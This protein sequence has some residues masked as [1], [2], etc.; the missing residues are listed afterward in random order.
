[1]SLGI[2]QLQRMMWKDDLL[3]KLDARI[4][5]AAISPAEF[6]NIEADEFRLLQAHGEYDISKKMQVLMQGFNGKIGTHEIVPFVTA[7]GTTI[8]VNRGWVPIEEK[9][10]EVSGNHELNGVIRKN[11]RKGYF[12]LENEPEKNTWYNIELPEMYAKAGVA[13]LGYYVE[14]RAVDEKEELTYPIPLPKKIDIYNQHLQYVI[15]WFGMSIALLIMY[16]FRFFHNKN[17]AKK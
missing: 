2:W 17:G 5:M 11:P 10:E 6:A 14:A 9:Y 16:Y 13:D 8:L 1:M 12:A 15:T 7:S 3:R 4:N